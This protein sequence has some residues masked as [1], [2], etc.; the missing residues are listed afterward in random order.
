[1]AP[2]LPIILEQ[3]Y[4]PRAWNWFDD[5]A[6]DYLG[7]YKYDL[8]N[9]KIIMRDEDIN[10][11]VNNNWDQAVGDHVDLGD[12]TDDEDDDGLIIDIGLII[13]DVKNN[14]QRILDDESVASMK[15]TAEAKMQTPRGWAD[16]KDE[17]ATK[18][19]TT[20]EAETV[21]TSTPSTLST[22]GFNVNAMTQEDLEKF[23]QQAA[24]KLK[25]TKI[26]SPCAA[27][28]VSD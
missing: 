11:D 26:A 19:S 4:G 23:M 22:Q 28:D 12:I 14:Q 8:D 6:K 1:M 27:N 20:K 15:S 2:F 18:N 5:R 3:E 24:E 10:E 21:S 7:G 16:D 13:L 9:H 17:E 25:L